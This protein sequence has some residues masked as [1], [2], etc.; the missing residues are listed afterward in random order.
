MDDQIVCQ[1]DGVNK[2][3]H[4]NTRQHNKLAWILNNPIKMQ[5][6][7]CNDFNT[8]NRISTIYTR[9]VCL[10]V[11]GRKCEY[12][13]ILAF[14][15]LCHKIDGKLGTIC[16]IHASY[17]YCANCAKGERGSKKSRGRRIPTYQFSKNKCST[18]VLI[19]NTSNVSLSIEGVNILIILYRIL[20]SKNFLSNIL[21]STI[22]LLSTI[23]LCF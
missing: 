9:S 15:A 19:S 11:F 18:N 1:T 5:S 8:L 21:E 13:A 22:V 12:R 4:K 16:N 7:K 3:A 6:N 23:Q 17:G 14:L 20:L 2:S 10:Y